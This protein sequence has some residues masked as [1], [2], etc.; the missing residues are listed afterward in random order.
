VVG[1][2]AAEIPLDVT[3][4]IDPDRDREGDVVREPAPDFLGGGAEKRGFTPRVVEPQRALGAP[5]QVVPPLSPPL[6]LPLGVTRESARS[7]WL[8]ERAIREHFPDGIPEDVLLPL[9]YLREFANMDGE[10]P[11]ELVPGVFELF[12]FLLQAG[13]SAASRAAAE[14]ERA[15]IVEQAEADARL[16]SD[17]ANA[18]ASSRMEWSRAQAEALVETAHR[19]AEDLLSAAGV[20]DEQRKSIVAELASAS[21]DKLVDARH[22]GGAAREAAPRRPA[23]PL[24]RRPG[25][26]RRGA[27]A[28]EGPFPPAPNIRP[29]RIEPPVANGHTVAPPAPAADPP[30]WVWT[31]QP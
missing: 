2:E 25:E 26:P 24:L 20:P 4:Q 21:W 29:P 5:A 16:V 14:P 7:I 19:T 18:D 15:A 31:P 28:A 1:R 9:M 3:P 22:V 23:V 11:D 12:P 6:A 30:D 17:Q 13:P 10:L 27:V 8:L